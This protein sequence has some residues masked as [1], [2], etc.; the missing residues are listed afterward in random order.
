M[1][2]YVVKGKTLAHAHEVLKAKIGNDV[3][4]QEAVFIHGLQS[5]WEQR[6][7]LLG[8]YIGVVKGDIKLVGLSQQEF[9]D[10]YE[11]ET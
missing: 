10:I 5:H 1:I 4:E 11:I 3:S 9:M 8:L 2:K 6:E 7:S